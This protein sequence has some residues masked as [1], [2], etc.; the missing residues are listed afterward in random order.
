MNPPRKSHR[1]HRLGMLLICIA[2]VMQLAR[3]FS[4]PG[5][6]ESAPFHSANDR[7]RWCTVASLVESGTYQIDHW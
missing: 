7:S 4:A 3:L 1:L 2:W 5:R 6:I